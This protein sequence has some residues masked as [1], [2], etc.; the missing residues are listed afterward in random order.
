[1]ADPFA[2]ADYLGRLRAHTAV[3]GQRLRRTSPDDIRAAVALK[4]LP[5][6]DDG[7]APGP[8]PTAQAEHDLLVCGLD[9]DE[10]A[11]TCPACIAEAARARQAAADEQGAR[12][13]VTAE[14]LRICRR[15]EQAD[16]RA[17]TAAIYAR[18]GDREAALS[19]RDDALADFF[20]AERALGE[21]LLLLLRTAVRHD[22]GTL[23]DYILDLIR[24]DVVDIALAVS[25]EGLRR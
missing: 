7:P 15:F 22:S 18:D 21:L 2:D 10:T 13:A 25:R 20:G 24:D 11:P 8:A 6:P 5:E 16:R 1:V 23:R 17:N 3:P 4:R 14:L 12:S 19:E 9:D